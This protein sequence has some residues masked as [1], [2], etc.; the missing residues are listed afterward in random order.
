VRDGTKPPQERI[1]AIKSVSQQKARAVRETLAKVISTSSPEPVTSAA[2][3]AL[4]SSDNDELPDITLSHWKE[5][6]PATRRTAAQVL[7]SRSKWS[8]RLLSGIETKSVSMGDVPPTVIR[9]LLTS[10][11]DYVRNRARK[12]I[13]KYRETTPDKAKLIAQKKQLILQGPIDLQKGHEI[14]Q[15]TCFTCHKLHGE[16]ADIGPD[17]TGVGR[18]SLDALLTNVI[19]PNQI[20]GA[21]YENVEVTTKD[22]RSISG[23]MVE[24]TDNRVKI[25]SLGPKEEVIPKS[26]IAG[27]RVSEMSVM[28]EGLEQMPD[29][30]FRNLIW[31][32]YSP[33]QDKKPMSVEEERQAFLHADK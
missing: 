25:L 13:G 28:P 20:I 8:Q 9:T 26:Q 16:G 5:F 31:F 4:G 7:S 10:K 1:D 29:D 18:S 12:I 14:A 24:N 3:T 30:D 27:I 19:D 11:D 22:D 2:M 6:S 15:K 23:R 17:L 21:G 32:I 33:P